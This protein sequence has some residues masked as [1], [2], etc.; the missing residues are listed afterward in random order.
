MLVLKTTGPQRLQKV[1]LERA[2]QGTS[3]S[4]LSL[5]SPISLRRTEPVLGSSRARVQKRMEAGEE[6]AIQAADLEAAEAVAMALRVTDGVRMVS[7]YGRDKSK[8]NARRMKAKVDALPP[9]PSRCAAT[10]AVA[11]ILT[12][13][14]PSRVPLSPSPLTAA[15]GR[16]SWCRAFPMLAACTC[17]VV[18]VARSCIVV[19]TEA[20]LEC[21]DAWHLPLFGGSL[22]CVE[23]VAKTRV[24][25]RRSF[26]ERGASRR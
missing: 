23:Q 1:P 15:F 8:L 11:F 7:F 25:F 6:Q 21:M 10:A 12:P 24:A 22:G 19:C 3:K 9:S 18:L 26:S 20:A 16:C 2:C 14:P 17:I 5:R 13:P 4:D